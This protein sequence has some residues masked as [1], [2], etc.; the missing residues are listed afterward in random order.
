MNVIAPRLLRVELSV[1]FRSFG[2]TVGTLRRAWTIDL[3]PI[4]GVWQCAPAIHFGERG[5][6]LDV[7]AE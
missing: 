1:K 3:P 6:R 2:V 7:W 5:V 4:D